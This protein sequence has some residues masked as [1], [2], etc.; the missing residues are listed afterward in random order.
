MSEDVPASEDAVDNGAEEV[1]EANLESGP[2][3]QARTLGHLLYSRILSNM[4][5]R[6]IYPFLPAVARGLG[7]SLSQASLLASVQG[8]VRMTAPLT[9][10]LSDRYGRRRVMESAL[11][12]L[13]ISTAMVF[14]TNRYAVALVAFAAIGLSRA[15]FDP[16]TQAYVGD[17]VPYAVRGQPFAILSMSW[18]LSWIIGVPISGFLI[19]RFGW[20]VPWGVIS[21]FLVVAFVTLRLFVPKAERKTTSDIRLNAFTWVRLLKFPHILAALFTGF[22]IVFA[23]E[24]IV[25]I[26][27]AYLENEF[28]LSVV[29]I[30]VL[31]IVMG[32]AELLAEGTSYLKTDRL[33]KKRS[34]LLGLLAFSIAAF[35]LPWMSVNVVLSFVG[36]ALVFFCFEFTIVSFF[37]LMSEVVPEV[38]GTAISM[39]VAGMGFAR[40]IAPIIATFLC[41]QAF[42]LTPNAMLTAATCLVVGF[43]AW[44][45]L[46]D[47]KSHTSEQT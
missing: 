12:M 25:I 42:D 36:F 17:K 9:G 2:Y 26:Y 47:D 11:L 28:A 19:E 21:L 22:G 10:H 24:N 15:I 4:S 40:L 23:V 8:G 33:G 29:T 43:V 38:R 5:F 46:P 27:S 32:A 30:G 34:I 18:A 41:Q 39:N 3:I 14:F 35:I 20:S 13:I 6:I 16:T 7:I 45:F 1:E 44:R 31:S 37:P